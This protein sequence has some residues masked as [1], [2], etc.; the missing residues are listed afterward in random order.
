MTSRH[1]GGRTRGKRRARHAGRL[2]AV[3]GAV[4]AMS[5]ALAACAGGASAA[6]KSSS[7][8]KHHGPLPK[9]TLAYP[10]PVSTQMVPLVAEQEGMF[11]KY[12]VTVNIT[13]LPATE[14]NTSLASG[15]VQMVVYSSPG[16]E[17]LNA[18]GQPIQWIATWEDHT[19]LYFLGGAGI[20]TVADLATKTVAV[21]AAG[22]TTA[23]LSEI[24]LNKAGVLN[25]A[26]VVPLGTVGATAT[27]FESGSAQ[28]V[29][30]DPPE[31]TLLLKAVPGSSTLVNL[32][33]GF[34]WV[35][36]GLAATS[37]WTKSHQAETVD[38]IKALIAARNFWEKAKNK[39]AVVSVIQTASK[40]TAT[41]ALPAYE[42]TLK[43]L[44]QL[45]TMVPSLA[46]EKSIIKVVGAVTPK[47]KE[48][49]KASSIIN[50]KYAKLAQK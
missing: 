41:D 49:A 36:G 27:A 7:S 33:N 45:R 9:I 18:G 42:T 6:N 48:N 37:T 20:K 35:G 2:A 5:L 21:S 19:G 4:G 31:N 12:G 24:I 29:I 38:V 46:V 22:S 34:T 30:F 25:K 15:Q 16:P 47:V 1:E 50:T 28:A 3:G 39:T 40:T 44:K 26:H 14:A 10:A 32:N 43:L 8:A 17:V 11:K 23:V 13:Y